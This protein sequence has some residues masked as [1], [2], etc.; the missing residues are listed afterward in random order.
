MNEYPEMKA[1][2]RVGEFVLIERVGEGGFGI[3]WKARHAEIQNKIVAIKFPKKAEFVD[4]MK[5]EANFQH[6]LNHPN[7]VKTLGLNLSNNPPYLVMEFAE[8]RNLRKLMQ[9]EGI[10]PPPHAIDIAI[11]ILDALAFAHGK[12]II[13]K[14]IKPENICV[15]KQLIGIGGKKQALFYKIKVMDFGLGMPQNRSDSNVILSGNSRTSGIRLHSGTMFYMA[16]EQ[17]SPHMKMDERADIYSLGVFLYEI[18]TGELPFGMDLPSELNPVIPQYLD[19]VVKKA[20]SIDPDQRYRSAREMQAALVGCRERLVKQISQLKLKDDA[21]SPSASV[22][23]AEPVQRSPLSLSTIG[24]VLAIFILFAAGALLISLFSGTSGKGDAVRESTEFF[25][26]SSEPSACDV[27][28]DGMMVGKTPYLLSNLS[29]GAHTIKLVR[30]NFKTRT[31]VATVG[32]GSRI[33]SITDEGGAVVSGL[34][35]MERESGQVE[36]ETPN[37]NGAKVYVDEVLRGK[38]PLKEQLQTGEYR[39]RIEAEGYESFEQ[40]VMVNANTAVSKTVFMKEKTSSPAPNVGQD[41][42]VSIITQPSEAHVFIDDDLR[43]ISPVKVQL[44]PGPHNVRIIRKYFKDKEV[45]IKVDVGSNDRFLIDLI[46]KMCNLKV[47]SDPAGASI[48]IDEKLAGQTPMTFTVSAGEHSVGV[49]HAGFGDMFSKMDISEDVNKDFAL[50]RLPPSTISINC[51]IKDAAVYVDGKFVNTVDKQSQIQVPAGTHKV[52]VGGFEKQVTSAA[53]ETVSIYLSADQMGLS[54][55]PE[56]KFTYGGNRGNP[57]E[58]PL[59]IEFTRAYVVG[60][61]EISN[62]M[63]SAFTNFMSETNDHSRCHPGEPESKKQT[64]HRPHFWDD[65]NFKKPD[66]PVC[67]IDFYDA[68][69]YAGFCGGRLPTEYEWEKAARGDKDLRSYPWGDDW[70]SNACNHGERAMKEDQ[71]AYE[72]LAPVNAFQ[73]FASPFGCLNMS[74]NAAEWCNGMFDKATDMR[75]VKGGHYNDGRN[76]LRIGS[77]NGQRPTDFSKYIGFRI[78]FDK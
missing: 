15:S 21:V 43:G 36:L 18:L 40:M 58:N 70:K 10:I 75:V 42:S 71:D 62:A 46:P 49:K 74:G 35:R 66:N 48:Y 65:D 2:D 13:H 29:S 44:K 8:G 30:P 22:T 31:F 4:L 55:V 45:P 9:E 38:T 27:L 76:L 23:Y 24:A 26:M 69:A 78:V 12:G 17:M 59:N 7:I 20:L 14:D 47:T 73:E 68:Y 61:Y 33:I 1:G 41:P 56:G 67:G 39:I 28:V 37:V 64:N 54:P 16:P 11:Q 19:A 3:V 52:I 50:R 25:R 32:D 51:E 77:R 60:K 34:I 6:N 5:R 53:G 57:W 72:I 63:Y